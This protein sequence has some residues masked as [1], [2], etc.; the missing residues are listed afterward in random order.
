MD[1]QTILKGSNFS[2]DEESGV[3][4]SVRISELE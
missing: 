1:K 3:N 4:V 2:L